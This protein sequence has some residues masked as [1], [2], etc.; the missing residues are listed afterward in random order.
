[1]KGYRFLLCALMVFTVSTQVLSGNQSD[2]NDEDKLLLLFDKCEKIRPTNPDS[3]VIIAHQA[4]DVAKTINK[5]YSI[6]KAEHL[7]GYCY[8]SRNDFDLATLPDVRAIE[9]ITKLN[10]NYS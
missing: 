7:L 6:A 8:Y 10:P 1:M 4:L 2:I 3:A 9:R 5:E